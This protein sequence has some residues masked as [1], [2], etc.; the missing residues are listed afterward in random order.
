LSAYDSN[1]FAEDISVSR[2]TLSAL[3]DYSDLLTKWQ[4][5]VNLVGASTLPEMWRRHFL[6]SAQLLDLVTKPG[7]V[8]LD[9]G[10]G[11][12]F[13]GL[14]VALLMQ[15]RPE[16][17]GTRVHLVESNGKKASF[18]QE[19]IRVTG[20][21]AE[22][23][24]TRLEDMDPFP[25]DVISARAVAPVEDLIIYAMPFLSSQPLLIFPKGRDVDEELTLASK[26]WNIDLDKYPSK[27]DP[28]GVIL[29]I[30]EVTRV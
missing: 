19:I 24:H 29:C 7:P 16:W 23:H 17:A 20:A 27:S 25:V 26:Y 14:V 28:E 13:P 5:T 11:A 1:Q 8:W 2:E 18:L 9:F 12:G 30:K 10:S 21:P 15:D 6:D 4:K 22:V 3:I